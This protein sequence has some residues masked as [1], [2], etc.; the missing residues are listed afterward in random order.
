MT[1]APNHR[2]SSRGTGIG[3]SH[4]R[5]PHVR[6]Y[7]RYHFIEHHLTRQPAVHRLGRVESSRLEQLVCRGAAAAPAKI[8]AVVPTRLD[9]A[10]DLAADGEEGGAPRHVGES[11][12]GDVAEGKIAEA[13]MVC[14]QQFRRKGRDGAI[15]TDAH[16]GEGLVLLVRH[17]LVGQ[18]VTERA[19]ELAHLENA[20]RLPHQREE[21]PHE[22][23]YFASL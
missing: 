21:P 11:M 6:F 10:A 4:V 16:D 1:V 3:G 17:G 2:P 23:R 9:A 18:E 8:T 7:S 14:A 22:V 13:G 12:R 15:V 19:F 5:W 20:R